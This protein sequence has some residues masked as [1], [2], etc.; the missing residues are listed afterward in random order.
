MSKSKKNKKRDNQ[1][2]NS[3]NLGQKKPSIDKKS[4]NICH[5]KS[6]QKS[7][8]GDFKICSDYVFYKNNCLICINYEDCKLLGK[9]PNELYIC[10][11]YERDSNKTV[12]SVKAQAEK[13]KIRSQSSKKTGLSIFDKTISPEEFENM[14]SHEI[15]SKFGSDFNPSDLVEKIIGLNYNEKLFSQVDE[16]DIPFAQNPIQFILDENFLDLNL[17][18]RQL[19][20]CLNFFAAFCPKCSDSNFIHTGI[21]VD[22]PIGNILDKTQ[23]YVDGICKKCGASRYDNF[24]NKSHPYYTHMIG[25]VGQRGGKTAL[26]VII[27][28]V[29]THFLLKIPSASTFYDLLKSVSTIHGT[30]VGL[31]YA[32]AYDNLFEPYSNILS[33]TPWFNM[34]HKFLHDEGIKLGVELLKFKNTFINYNHKNFSFYPA[35]PD[36][37][38]L[39]GRSRAF[40]MIDEI[41]WFTGEGDQIRNVDEVY[42]A[43]DNSLMTLIPK[44][45]KKIRRY[46]WLL[47]P[48]SI[49]IS[50]PRS[51][52]DK[53]MRM[54][55]L[56]QSSR[57]MFGFKGP[58]WWFN[59]DVR[60]KDLAD[61]YLEDPVKAERDFGAN[62][63]YGENTYI[64][65]PATLVP[66]FSDK[67]KNIFSIIKYNVVKG[68]LNTKLMYPTVKFNAIHSYPSVLCIDAGYNN[69]SYCCCLM[70]NYKLHGKEEDIVYCSGIIEIQP[71]PYPLSFPHIYENVI[72]KIINSYNVK[73]IIVDRW[74]SIDI[75][76]R[77]AKD[78]K[79]A[80]IQ[81]SPKRID[82]DNLKSTI[83]A[84]DILFP[85]L[86][87]D[88]NDLLT[89]DKEVSFIIKNS[90][91]NHLFLQL[92]LSV[93]N[94]RNVIKGEEMTD[95]I[96][97][98]LVIGYY[99]LRGE[100]Y[101]DLFKGSGSERN[102]YYSNVESII[103]TRQTVKDINLQLNDGVRSAQGI[104]SASSRG[105]GFYGNNNNF[106]IGK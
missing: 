97:R 15:E 73:A 81:Y 99:A 42:Q 54:Y 29:L 72:M 16:R 11:N 82:F 100:E 6:V 98:A 57:N 49:N 67:R 39:R 38:K 91:S 28:S 33:S 87:R 95:D 19:Q 20:V 51:K 75:T 61:K 43:L 96:L 102:I 45:K 104:G 93:D 9:N 48:A 78:F 10:V 80:G 35:G 27:G 53:G 18:P 58:T 60:K 4:C 5:Y 22:T 103:K 84:E 41:S 76:Q 85:K 7:C 13:K 8:K 74:Q 64:S 101:K 92:L 14:S 23:L 66:I 56:S 62:P 17:F 89:L 52:T 40:Y 90:P 36:K 83:H 21:K 1:V 105:V 65:S 37:R 24:K 26:S 44:S 71:K 106:M 31:R 55:K 12:T 70:H 3:T 68:S 86:E 47:A 59:P 34:Y 88:I 30:F 2:R 69:N 50:S 63:P 79:I 25:V 77:V 46:P 32:D 94:G